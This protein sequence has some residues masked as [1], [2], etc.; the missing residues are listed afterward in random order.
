MTPNQKMP[1]LFIGHGS[2]MNAVEQNMF[3]EGWKRIA[4]TLP[5]PKAVLCVSAHWVT[6]GTGVTAMPKPKTIHDFYG[7]PEELYQIRYPAKGSMELAKRVQKLIQS[8]PVDLDLEW[9]LDHGTWVPLKI[10]F[11]KADVPVVQL[12]LNA[13]LSPKQHYAIG[14][15]L[16]PLREEG[17]LI[18]GSGNC[19]HNL[20]RMDWD[21]EP[22]KWALDFDRF[23][24]DSLS[25]RNDKALV[26]YESRA[27]AKLAHP[28]NEHYLPLLYA[29]GAAGTDKPR[30]FNESIFAA[31][32]SM[33][34]AAFGLKMNQ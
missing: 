22:F 16:T 4:K 8:V 7:F 34:C 5:K 31:S 25:T 12:S 6:E 29:I 14:K 17:V 28:S 18:L 30:F 32:L 3:V 2:P 11:P 9:G 1:V 19:V 20:M 10:L 33:R 23:V 24:K 21:G 15:E 27:D 26:D 13:N